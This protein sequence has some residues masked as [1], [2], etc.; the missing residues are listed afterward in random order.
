MEKIC[1]SCFFFIL[2][3]TNFEPKSKLTSGWGVCQKPGSDTKRVGGKL[4]GGEPVW[5]YETCGDF[6]PRRTPR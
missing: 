2:T 6:K 4:V 3:G 5:D 1:K